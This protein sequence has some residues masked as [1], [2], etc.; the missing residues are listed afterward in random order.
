[1]VKDIKSG[2]GN[3]FAVIRVRGT[4]RVVYDINETMDMLHLYRKNFCTIVDRKQLG[5]IK[6]VKDYVAYGEVSKEV[7]DLLIKTRGEKTI[8]KDG[9]ETI[10]KYFR[11]QPPK[12]G[13]GRKG[14]KVS[15]SNSGAL[16][17]RGEQ[18]NDLIK[19]ML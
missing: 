5:M 7:E 18:I 2:T 8:G 17:Y 1:M 14:I 9:K 16:G 15:F 3:R 6:K 12:K 10:K 11:L 13:F 4:I 19:R